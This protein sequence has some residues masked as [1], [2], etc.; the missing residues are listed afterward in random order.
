MGLIG[1]A[2]LTPLA[3]SALRRE[4][5]RWRYA[6]PFGLIPG[7]FTVSFNLLGILIGAILVAAYYKVRMPS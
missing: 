4:G 7:V 1:A 3:I 2:I 5:V 6:I